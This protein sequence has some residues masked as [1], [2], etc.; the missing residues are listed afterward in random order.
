MSRY[1]LEE[2]DYEVV[3]YS[4]RF[5]IIDSEIEIEDRE[6]EDGSIAYLH[7]MDEDTAESI[8]KALEKQ[9]S[10][11]VTDTYHVMVKDVDIIEYGECP[12]CGHTGLKEHTHKH[13]WWCG[14]KLDWD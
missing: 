7:D 4:P 12:S 1:K 6:R 8:V 10:R 5:K 3:R 14:Q 11:R 2:V 13:C 9:I